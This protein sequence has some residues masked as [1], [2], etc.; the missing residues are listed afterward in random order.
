MQLNIS[1]APPVAGAR[2]S[3]RAKQNDSRA[4]R[5][6]KKEQ[7]QK[8]SVED[9][10]AR[11]LNRPATKTKKRER[12]S[13]TENVDIDAKS[14]KR[15]RKPRDGDKVRKTHERKPA[16]DDAPS[17][18]QVAELD[19]LEQMKKN[20]HH[21]DEEEEDNDVTMG[22]RKDKDA[23]VVA[24]KESWS[25][26]VE[27]AQRDKKEKQS[28]IV[29]V[30][31][32]DSA[33]SMRRTRRGDVK[34]EK[35]AEAKDD[36]DVFS[37]FD[38]VAA[39]TATTT[40][41]GKLS[42]RNVEYEFDQECA[43]SKFALS[44]ALVEQLEDGMSLAHPTHVQQATIPLLVGEQKPAD[45]LVKARTGSGKTLSFLI[46]IVQQLQ[47]RET[48]V[49]R[50]EG[51]HAIVLAPTRELAQQIFQVLTKLLKPYHYLVPGLLTGGE[52]RKSEKGRLRKGVT[53]LV[54]T[55]GRLLDHL[56]LT[57]SFNVAPLRWFV[58]DE[59]D[60]LLDLGF[61]RKVARILKLIDSRA[62]ASRQNILLS[63]TLREDVE[64]LACLSLD[65]PLY[66]DAD[67]FDDDD[68][69]NDG[70]RQSSSSS[71]SSSSD[72]S[73]PRTLQQFYTMVPIKTRL[74][75]L[76]AFVRL[77]QKSKMLIF[78][79]NIDSVNFLHALMKQATVPSRAL[80][81][82][83]RQREKMALQ[84]QRHAEQQATTTWQRRRLAEANATQRSEVPLID[85]PVYKLHGSLT[86]LERKTAFAEFQQLRAGGIM[87][88]TDVAA[89]GWDLS[90]LEWVVQYDPPD[91]PD[92]YVHRVGRTARAGARG[93]SLLFLLPHELGFIE[94][95]NARGMHP[96]DK[97]VHKW[98]RSLKTCHLPV[99]RRHVAAA[100][101][102]AELSL[103]VAHE[104][105]VRL[106]QM[107]E[108][109]RERDEAAKRRRQPQQQLTQAPAQRTEPALH[110]LAAKAFGSSVRAYATHSS[111]VKHIFH[112]RKLHLGHYAKAFALVEAP[113][114][115]GERQQREH[116]NNNAAGK[117]DASSRRHS[118]NPSQKVLRAPKT[119]Q[120][121]IL[122]EF[123]SGM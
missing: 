41:L 114:R 69:A 51:S 23:R 57:A 76:L 78:C 61:E 59:A 54:A 4:K 109:D 83:E 65:N 2:R 116:S 123:S 96:R 85:A 47:A 119:A 80:T 37:A 73:T 24:R 88:C 67:R 6:Q 79:S 17:A 75:A 49:T 42:F 110:G 34:K 101:G 26:R 104:L 15:Q 21:D 82:K 62:S 27:R 122:S 71:S 84:Q 91:H 92:E 99:S 100:S 113:R 28:T 93:S 5:K 81:F 115:L 35:V 70:E 46:P 20:L 107:V 58:L 11:T 90:D 44:K 112:P 86:Q 103:V 36:S 39:A 22:E 106:Q 52:N 64:R 45:V 74:V 25:S 30:A 40:T 43:W 32:Q 118:T 1:M 120:A 94:V 13:S 89:R 31:A 16:E 117:S 95:L 18:L 9:Y 50:G 98:L 14:S 63:A 33:A 48:R 29:D 121:A 55:P 72:Q 3:R 8:E 56:E 111:E 10:L 38:D 68:E 19:I 53:I 105:Q 77:K 102:A 66:V 7:R 97:P 12:S 87:V 60:R 108:A